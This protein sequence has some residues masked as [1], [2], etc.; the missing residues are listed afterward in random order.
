MSFSGTVASD[1]MKLA[2]VPTWKKPQYIDFAASDFLSLRDSLI[3]YIKAVYP[4]EYDYFAESD[5]GMML[6][7]CTAYMG[8]VMSMKA[9]MLANENFFA[10]ARQKSSV[11][12]L[13]ELIGVRMR[14]PLSAA[15]DA[16]ATFTASPTGTTPRYV[17]TPSQRTFTINSPEDG[18]QLTYTLYKTVNGYVEDANATGDVTLYWNESD[19]PAAASNP[20]SVYTN[21]VIQEGAFVTDTGDFAATEGIKTIPL[22][23]SPVIEGSVSVFLQD[24][25]SAASGAYTE[26]DNVYFASGA[27]DKIFEIVYDDSY[28]ATVVFGDGTVG[29]SPNATASY[30]VTYRVGGGS[31]GNLLPHAVDI[32]MNATTDSTPLTAQVQN[33]SVAAGGANAESIANAKKYAPLT[34]ARQDRLVTLEDYKVFANTHIASVG[35]VGK[36]NAVTRKAYS[37]ANVIDIYILEKASDLQLQKATPSFKRDLLTAINKKK[38]ATDEIVIVDG[39]IRTLD[40]V[41]TVSVDKEEKLNQSSI[42]SKVR[43]KILKYMNADNR[44]F[45]EP[46]VISDLNRTI[47]EVESVRMSSIDNI[48]DNILVDFNEIIQLNNL[49][50]VFNYLD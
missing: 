47:F 23:Q 26:V 9:D 15:A 24:S 13:L 31:R 33:I 18:A 14:G 16:K 10:T 40:L 39:L 50:I 29:V 27:G 6:I 19:N 42:I 12:K 37:S 17:L 11:K 28:G 38:M 46:L 22:T 25:Q 44:D 45:G 30:F 3:N 32:S 7:E 4:R 41:I 34:F 20:S 43:G 8:A 21:L 49:T 35:T 36:A 48:S 1:F 5:L 2:K